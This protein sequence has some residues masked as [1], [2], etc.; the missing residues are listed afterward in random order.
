MGQNC[1]ALSVVD[2]VIE[3]P[4]FLG[5]HLGENGVRV[6]FK[7]AIHT[8]TI[9]CTVNRDLQSFVLEMPFKTPVA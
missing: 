4:E 7:L 1:K 2:R 9:R 3:E 8:L 5:S 6:D